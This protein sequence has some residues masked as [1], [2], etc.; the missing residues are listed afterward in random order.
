MDKLYH[1]TTFEALNSILSSKSIWLGNVHYMNDKNEMRYLFDLL[2]EDLLNDY[3]ECENIISK[4][5]DDQQKR[6]ANKPAYI[7]SMSKDED[8]AAQW[9]RYSNRGSGVCIEFDGKALEQI[10]K[11]KAELKT[12]YYSREKTHLNYKKIMGMYL[13]GKGNLS[14]DDKVD[15]NQLF[16]IGNASAITYK[17]KSF[18]SENEVRLCAFYGLEGDLHYIITDKGVKEYYSISLEDGS[19]MKGLIKKIILGPNASVDEYIFKRYLNKLSKEK[20]ID[21]SGIQIKNSD[22]PLR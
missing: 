16:E 8:D 7:F 19:N 18:K 17:H 15:L 2:K 9:D 21:I 12:V 13:K 10:T 1:Y 22:S 5:F 11:G 20:H 14:E 3:P 6:L 4:M